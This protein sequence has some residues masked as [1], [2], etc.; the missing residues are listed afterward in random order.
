MS[1]GSIM[2]FKVGELSIELA[3]FPKESLADFV[4]PGLQQ[5]G[6]RKYLGR[7]SA[8]V[9]EDEF[10]WYEKVRLNKNSLVWGIW[11]IEGDARILIGN[12]SLNDIKTGHIQ[13]ATSGSMI[14]R[15]EYW[16]K[17]IASAAHKA[18]T[19]YAFQHLGLHRIMSAVIQGNEA[20][21]KALM[22]SGYTKVYVE[23]N[24]KF[25]D[26]QL[27]H[28]DCLEC[29]NPNEPFWSQWWHGDQPSKESLV[30]R[31]DTLKILSWAQ[32]NVELP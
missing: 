12:T 17:G 16:G 20:S 18:R 31:D 21:L 28:L 13:Q 30:A 27:R 3:P 7:P 23:R 5:E 32:Q 15:K 1:F 11:V 4:S 14:F 22:R 9:L 10:D 19:W 26:G 8:P 24:E 25:I 2:R 6:V 29:L